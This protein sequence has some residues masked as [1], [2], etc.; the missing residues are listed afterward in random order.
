MG[1]T[2]EWVR[3]SG[4]QREKVRLEPSMKV[5]ELPGSAEA[6]ESPFLDSE[7]RGAGRGAGGHQECRS[8]WSVL[9]G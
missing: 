6:P 7:R 2:L 8:L 3:S 4:E 1:E 9:G 5:T